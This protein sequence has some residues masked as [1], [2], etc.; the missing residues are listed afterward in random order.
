[1]EKKL[2]E[3][4]AVEGRAIDVTRHKQ[5]GQIIDQAFPDNGDLNNIKSRVF[6]TS[7]KTLLNDFNH[8]EGNMSIFQPAVDITDYMLVKEKEDILSFISSL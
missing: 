4:C 1:M 8:F 2:V 5:L 3:K 7:K 6:L